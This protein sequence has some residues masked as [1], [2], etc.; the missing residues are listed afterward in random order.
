MAIE[1]QEAIAII[2]MST[3]TLHIHNV[4]KKWDGQQTEE[5]LTEQGYHLSNCSWGAFDGKINDER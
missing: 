5:W 1:Q 3:S 2:D 4:P